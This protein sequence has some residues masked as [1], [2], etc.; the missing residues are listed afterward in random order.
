MLNMKRRLFLKQSLAAS[1]VGLAMGA[2]LITPKAVLAAWP[3]AAFEDKDLNSALNKL[4]GSSEMTESGDIEVSAPEIAE[5]GAVVPVK[6]TANMSG[7]ES[8]T[9]IAENNPYPIITSFQLGE[10]AEAFAS[11]RMK[12]GKS[13]D[14]IAVVKANGKLFSGRRPVKVTIGGCGG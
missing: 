11:T 6:V 4:L 8:I 14:A 9:I 2:G 3:K 10:G 7:V 5:N 13:G 12:M 1:A